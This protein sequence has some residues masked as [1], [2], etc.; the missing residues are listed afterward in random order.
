MSQPQDKYFY[1]LNAE[2]REIALLDW[3]RFYELMG[4]DA[5]QKAKI[6]LLRS[7]GETI[8]RIEMKLGVSRMQVRHNSKGDV[9]ACDDKGSEGIKNNTAKK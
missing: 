2:L 9:C 4:D 6:C 5:M 8:G 3:A 1:G 7:R